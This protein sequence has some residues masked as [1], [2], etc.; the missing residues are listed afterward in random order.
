[1]Y[2]VLIFALNYLVHC[3]YEETAGTVCYRKGL[4]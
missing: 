4:F 3:G 2:T 1:M